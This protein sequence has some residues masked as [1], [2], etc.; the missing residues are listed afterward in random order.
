MRIVFSL[1]FVLLFSNIFLE[2]NAQNTIF[3]K[4]AGNKR[5]LISI[6]V[7][8]SDREGRRIPGL[9]KEDFTVYRDGVKQKITSF[10]TEQEPVTIALLLDTSGSTQKILDEI[11]DAAKDF[12]DLLN[13]NDKCL[14]AT[15]DSRVNI[16]TPFTSNRQELKK[17]LDKIQNAER[18]GTI[19]YSAVNEI[20]QNSFNGV[21]GRK[22]IVLLS[23]GKDFGSNI[24]GKDLLNTLEETDVSIYPIFYQSGSAVIDKSGIVAEEKAIEEPKKQT[25]ETKKQ[26]KPKTKKKVYTVYI[27]SPGNTYSTDEIKLIDKTAATGAVSSLRELSDISAGRFYLS[28]DKLNTTFKLVAAELRQKYML[29]FYLEGTTDENTVRDIIVKVDRPNVVVQARTKLRPKKF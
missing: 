6:P 11:K 20:V 15:F 17:S 3:D 27:P 28:D 29:S 25:R 26:K 21:V 8:V 10:A 2:V 18:E 7:V 13:P 4:P 9:K 16:L 5:T 24:L 12:I 19:I 23:D 22:A 14:I 1:F